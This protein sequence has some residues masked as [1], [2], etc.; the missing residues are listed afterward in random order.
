MIY[1]DQHQTNVIYST[2]ETP[3]KESNGGAVPEPVHDDEVE[4]R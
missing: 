2:I 1:V 3:R 4:A